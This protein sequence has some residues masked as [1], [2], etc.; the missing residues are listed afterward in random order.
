M[1]QPENPQSLNRYAYVNNNLLVYVDADG[2][3][4]WLVIPALAIVA[5]VCTRY[6]RDHW[7][8]LKQVVM[9]LLTTHRSALPIWIQALDGHVESVSAEEMQPAAQEGYRY[10]ELCTTYGGVRQRWLVVW[11]AQAE[12]RERAALRRRVEKERQ[13]AEKAWKVLLRG[14]FPRGRRREEAVAAWAQRW[15]FY[16]VQVGALLAPGF[17]SRT[18]YRVVLTGSVVA[19]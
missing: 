7:P 1:P 4:P 8:D 17:G 14:E 5:I 15:S 12:E 16:G 19:G 13:A 9:A 11:S 18:V 6:S 10:T 2:R 3:F